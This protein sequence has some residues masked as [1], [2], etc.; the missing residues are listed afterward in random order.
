MLRVSSPSIFVKSL[1]RPYAATSGGRSIPVLVDHATGVISHLKQR[2]CECGR[3]HI[4]KGRVRGKSGEPLSEERTFAVCDDC[5]KVH[6]Y[7]DEAED[8][9][10]SLIWLRDMARPMLSKAVVPTPKGKDG[11]V[12]YGAVG[13]GDS[14]W[15][16]M[17]SEGPLRGRHIL[18]SKRPDGL[19]AVTGGVKN[20]R[21]KGFF[22]AA[23]DFGKQRELTPKE[24]AKREAAEKEAAEAAQKRKAFHKEHAKTLQELDEASRTVRNKIWQTLGVETD[25]E[26]AAKGKSYRARVKQVAVQAGYAPA[27]AEALANDLGKSAESAARLAAAAAHQEAL[28]NAYQQN[29]KAQQALTKPAKEK[30]KPAEPVLSEESRQALHVL[31]SA[32]FTAADL[33]APPKESMSPEQRAK[34][35]EAVKARLEE[36]R[37]EQAEAESKARAEERVRRD[38]AKAAG[39]DAAELLKYLGQHKDLREQAKQLRGGKSP[40]VPG[41]EFSGVA[42]SLDFRGTGT[43]ILGE[44]EAIALAM[45]SLEE[46]DIQEKNVGLYERVA[47]LAQSGDARDEDGNPLPYDPNN[48]FGHLNLHMTKGGAPEMGHKDAGAIRTLNRIAT[49]F[50]GADVLRGEL[51]EGL[52]LQS[53]A[54]VLIDRLKREGA[55]MDEV[56]DFVGRQHKAASDALDRAMERD[57][58]L[59][60][61][62]A[63]I[64]AQAKT[65]AGGNPQMAEALRTLYAADNLARQHEN[66]GA[67]LGSLEAL[68]SFAL[69]LDSKQSGKIEMAV[70]EDAAGFRAKVRRMVGP[71]AA[72]KIK[73]KTKRDG[74][75]AASLN[76]SDLRAYVDRGPKVS[77]NERRLAAISAGKKNTADFKVPGIKVGGGHD[78]KSYRPGQQADIRNI[79]EQYAILA[80]EKGVPMAQKTIRTPGLFINREVGGGKTLIS[81]SI[82]QHLLNTQGNDN[83]RTVVYTAPE[84]LLGNWHAEAKKWLEDPSALVFGQHPGG[85]LTAEDAGE[86][87]E[88]AAYLHNKEGL[89]KIAQQ[90]VDGKAPRRLIVGQ[91]AL[92]AKVT[93]RLN[94][95]DGKGGTKKG[96][97]V[98]LPLVDI[99]NLTQPMMFAQDEPQEMTTAKRGVLGAAGRAAVRLGAG[100]ADNEGR[101]LIATRLALTATPAR[102][103]AG[104]LFDMAN[105]VTKGK[106][107]TRKSFMA[108]NGA[109]GQGTTVFE[110]SEGDAILNRLRSQMVSERGAKNHTPYSAKRDVAM[111]DWQ[112]AAQARTGAE[113]SPHI[114]ALREALARPTWKAGKFTVRMASGWKEGH[115]ISTRAQAEA[116]LDRMTQRHDAEVYK[117][118]YGV[119]ANGS[120]KSNP[121]LAKLAEE[122]AHHDK[123]TGG[124][125]HILWAENEDSLRGIKQML[126]EQYP[127]E[128]FTTM[129]TAGES[130]ANKREFQ[131]GQ[132]K[133][134]I[135]NHKQNAGHNMQNAGS[136]HFL[137]LPQEF[138]SYA[139]A[140]G[141]AE[142]DPRVGD[143]LLSHIDYTDN[144]TVARH[145]Q[146]LAFEKRFVSGTNLTI[147][148]AKERDLNT[149]AI[150]EPVSDISHEAAAYA[151]DYRKAA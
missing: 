6:A 135:M 71:G 42:A 15:I 67:A 2:E 123:L 24:K 119:P 81:L 60:K 87:G 18:I 72:K 20:L 127:K 111:A 78:V 107:G 76:V 90:L 131:A 110:N 50:T 64:E 57:A 130:E 58:Q 117:S 100:L 4:V 91:N 96:K 65:D 36:K 56:R 22:H 98:E 147:R 63:D 30:P 149:L 143:P 113:Y 124:H 28:R 141:R 150:P 102:T 43:H 14:I 45:R 8:L 41:A 104:Q 59:Q 138:V 146:K 32:D 10:K 13:A 75:I 85:K 26:R 89:S 77:A 54:H 12:D 116:A 3:V 84:K 115:E 74:T 31:D 61:E 83:H 134:V 11:R 62:A 93:V 37:R 103:H 55:N 105:W 44:D 136:A 109:L 35:S 114:A 86:N 148:H 101:E 140:R 79:M 97:A 68:G 108:K 21:E 122:I 7:G 126:R 33:P 5:G 95:D 49:E 144:P 38:A 29:R 69:A 25:A 82:G 73:I 27:D 99:I 88:S 142:R 121:G 139:Q 125:Q 70:G 51:V 129:W 17:T 132:H 53:T 145:H 137:G 39:A 1:E 133:F 128:S 47:Q 52:G 46:K 34:I 16:T 92:N 48:P 80:E 23:L 112:K 9:K 94:E 120:W 118:L 106:V 151:G 19:F 40:S 66:L